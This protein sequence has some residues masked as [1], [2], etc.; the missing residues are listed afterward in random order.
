MIDHFPFFILIGHHH[1]RSIN[2]SQHL[3]NIGICLD[4][5]NEF[6]S[7]PIIQKIRAVGDDVLIDGDVPERKASVR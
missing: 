7:V 1:D 2:S 6:R 4:W 3:H 5:V